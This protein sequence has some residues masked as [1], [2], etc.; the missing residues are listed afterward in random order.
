M[1]AVSD[2]TKSYRGQAADNPVLSHLN[3]VF[4]GSEDIGI[5]GGNGSGKSMLI[6]SMLIRLLAGMDSPDG[7]EI[8]RSPD[9][10][11]SYPLSYSG[12]FHPHMSGRDRPRARRCLPRKAR[13][14]TCVVPA[15]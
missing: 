11:V 1:I 15:A 3:A 13:P 14:M 7:G 5:L 8:I 4:D 10:R 6:R 2:V 12:F 9:M